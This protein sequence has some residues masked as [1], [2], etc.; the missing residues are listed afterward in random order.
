[1]KTFSLAFI[2]STTFVTFADNTGASCKKST[3]FS[4]TVTSLM[5][6]LTSARTMHSFFNSVGAFLNTPLCQVALLEPRAKMFF[7]T[8]IGRRFSFDVPQ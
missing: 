5:S 8:N 7:G 4:Y 1:M 3:R 2:G 6:L